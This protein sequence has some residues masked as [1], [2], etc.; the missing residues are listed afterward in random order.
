MKRAPATNGARGS[1]VSSPLCRENDAGCP[2]T[3]IAVDLQ[4]A[5]VEVERAEVD[6]SDRLDRGTRGGDRTAGHVEVEVEGVV[7]DVVAGVAQQGEV[8][9]ADAAAAGR[10]PADSGTGVASL[11]QGERR[12]QGLCQNRPLRRRGGGAHGGC[13]AVSSHAF[14]DV[15]AAAIVPAARTVLQIQDE[16][17]ACAPGAHTIALHATAAPLPTMGGSWNDVDRFTRR[18]HCRGRRPPFRG[19]GR[20]AGPRA[21]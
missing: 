20:H 19:T 16:P 1:I 14:T 11:R 21:W 12:G 18:A 15:A 3:V 6:Q 13:I 9:I 10:A 2:S 7:L 17:D 4:P 8:G 5:K